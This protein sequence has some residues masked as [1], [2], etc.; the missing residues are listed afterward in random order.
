MREA[1]SLWQIICRKAG[2]NIPLT[3]I[4]DNSLPIG[5]YCVKGYN[6]RHNSTTANN[7]AVMAV[8]AISE[9]LFGATMDEPSEEAIQINKPFFDIKELVINYTPRLIRNNYVNIGASG[10][11]RTWMHW[12]HVPT[13]GSGGSDFHRS[14]FLDLNAKYP[15]LGP[16]G[17]KPDILHPDFPMAICN[18][19]LARASANPAN[20]DVCS[21]FEIDG[22]RY[23][24]VLPHNPPP[25]YLNPFERERYAVSLSTGIRGFLRVGST[26]RG[27]DGIRYPVTDGFNVARELLPINSRLTDDSTPR[28]NYT[29]YYLTMYKRV[30]DYFD[31]LGLTNVTFNVLA[32]HAYRCFPDNYPDID[33]SRFHVYYTSQQARAWT[34][35]QMRAD[36]K[37]VLRWK[38]TGAKVIWRPNHLFRPQ[39]RSIARMLEMYLGACQFDGIQAAPF[40]TDG[41]MEDY[42]ACFKAMRI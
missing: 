10:W 32:Y 13:E 19:Y 33:L 16:V 21:L 34:Y 2:V 24:W 8:A 29:A 42:L 38:A 7:A 23:W 28:Y 35:D 41:N 17:E 14:W 27:P 3:F 1:Q 11:H 9:A 22:G 36:I 31:S 30:Q 18:E 6:V 20:K 26:G 12:H 39:D 25:D 15:Q 5:V 4:T 40:Y 37:D